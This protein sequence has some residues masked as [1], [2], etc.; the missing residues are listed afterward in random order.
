[1]TGEKDEKTDGLDTYR[2][3][4]LLLNGAKMSYGQALAAYEILLDML[5]NAPEQFKAL[6]ALVKHKV[7][8]TEIDPKA[9]AALRKRWGIRADGSV[10]PDLAAVLEAAYEGAADPDL[11]S[12]RY[13]IV[14][15]DP[16]HLAE[17]QKLEDEK[18]QR[19][20]R[21]IFAPDR[22]GEGRSR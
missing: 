22:P 3:E 20:L 8:T 17:L 12:L 21:D 16:S 9:R 10:R 18:P 15:A 6:V 14:H 19:L 5:E 1:V 13:P 2:R 4:A 11:P 7:K